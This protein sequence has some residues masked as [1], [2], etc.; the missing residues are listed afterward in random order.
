M[1]MVTWFRRFIERFAE[2]AEHLT[3]LLWKKVKGVWCELQENS[4]NKLKSCLLSPPVLACPRY[5]YPFV[6]QCDASAYAIGGVLTQ[7]VETMLLLFI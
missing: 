2:Y 1:G 6:F 3:I 7:R 4:F 5:E